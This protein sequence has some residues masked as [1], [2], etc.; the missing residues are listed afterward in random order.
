[1]IDEQT[2]A[3]FG[4][5]DAEACCENRKSRTMAPFRAPATLAALNSPTRLGSPDFHFDPERLQAL[6]ERF[7]SP[8]KF[9]PEAFFNRR[10]LASN[11]V[12]LLQKILDLALA[13]DYADQVFE[14]MAEDEDVA[15][16]SGTT[17]VST[18][19][20]PSYAS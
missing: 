5:T 13:V 19:S 11:C 10:K 6:L 14:S 9:E 16:R 8:P 17:S 18:W 1:M 15:L 12:M 2:L 20:V 3:H 4:A 7:E